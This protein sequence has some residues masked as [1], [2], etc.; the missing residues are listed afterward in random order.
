MAMW[1]YNTVRPQ[2]LVKYVGG[3]EMAQINKYTLC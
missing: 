3:V 2:M 1:K